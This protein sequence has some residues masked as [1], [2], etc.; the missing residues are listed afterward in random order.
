MKK[1][2][3]IVGILVFLLS[4]GGCLNDSANDIV[5]EAESEISSSDKVLVNGKYYGDK[6]S[7][8]DIISE[9]SNSKSTLTFYQKPTSL[10]LSGSGKITLVFPRWILEESNLKVRFR[11]YNSSYNKLEYI[12][13]NGVNTKLAIREKLFWAQ[14][15][16]NDEFKVTVYVSGDTTLDFTY[17]SNLTNIGIAGYCTYGVGVIKN[18]NVTSGGNM[19][20]GGHARNWPANARIEGFL[21]GNT[22]R[23]GAIIVLSSPPYNAFG[24]VGVVTKVTS[25][26][27]SYKSMNNGIYDS[28][29]PKATYDYNVANAITTLFGEFNVVEESLTQD[30]IESAEYIYYKM[31]KY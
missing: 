2:V 11:T 17:P 1:F 4:F 27:L 21:T 23:V 19:P 25:S 12:E 28:S 30:Y 9:K 31:D 15:L 24:H 10:G 13:R 14:Y 3:S 29:W 6:I 22:P 18:P 26:T 20:W 16:R 5:S 8:E 7:I